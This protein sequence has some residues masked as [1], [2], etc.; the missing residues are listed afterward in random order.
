MESF[1]QII[2]DIGPLDRSRVLNHA[3][4]VKAVMVIQSCV[5]DHASL[6]CKRKS[7]R[8]VPPAISATLS[9]KRAPVLTKRNAL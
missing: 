7:V 1:Q 5:A 6:W 9:M 8:M 3:N 4:S 2:S